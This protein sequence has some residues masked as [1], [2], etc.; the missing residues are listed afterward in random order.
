ML[1]TGHTLTFPNHTDDVVTV[2]ENTEL[3]I[4][5]NINMKDLQNDTLISLEKI[6][7]GV[8]VRLCSI[9]YKVSTGE[10]VASDSSLRC[11]RTS[12]P[13]SFELTLNV[14]RQ[15]D[16][17]TLVWRSSDYADANRTLSLNITCKFS[18]P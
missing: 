11:R 6:N 16:R 13:T 5:F 3:R 12:G 7:K 8:P 2:A 9:L 18:I 15:D 4:P 17:S 14:T 1:T 10:Y